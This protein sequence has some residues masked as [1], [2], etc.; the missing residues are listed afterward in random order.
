MPSNTIVTQYQTLTRSLVR[1]YDV[2]R[3][4]YSLNL[5]NRASAHIDALSDALDDLETSYPFLTRI[6]A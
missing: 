5:Y 4:A 2:Q 1:W 6:T 3:D